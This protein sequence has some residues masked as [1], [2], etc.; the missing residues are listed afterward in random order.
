MVISSSRLKKKLISLLCFCNK[1]FGTNMSGS[2]DFQAE[3]TMEY[4]QLKEIKAFDD[5][6]A[7]IKGLVDAGILEIPR[8]FIMPPHELAE[9]LI[10]AN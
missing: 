2:K 8:I 10:E 9:E 5:T 1:V 3:L 6:K 4:D 7:G